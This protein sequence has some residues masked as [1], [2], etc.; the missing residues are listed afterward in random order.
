MF[1]HRHDEADVYG[2]EPVPCPLCGLGGAERPEIEPKTPA[3][4]DSNQALRHALF[5]AQGGDDRTVVW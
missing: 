3:F 5:D 4:E 1:C 2:S